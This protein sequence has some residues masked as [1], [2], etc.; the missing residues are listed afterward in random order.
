LPQRLSDATA[1]LLG[2]LGV[3]IRAG[4]RV[5]EIR[6]D[7]ICLAS[8]DFIPSELVVWSAGIRGPD[9]LKDLDGLEASPSGQLVVRPTLQT[10]S[11]DNIFAMGDCA[12]LVPDGE[13]RPIPPRAQ[14]AHQQPK[15]PPLR[16]TPWLGMEDSNRSLS[17]SSA[18]RPAVADG[19]PGE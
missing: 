11:D 6:P 18:R 10:T 3:E 17:I 9:V 15:I 2:Q 16:P 8:G 14:A 5:T 7:G 13:K 1:R 4:A 19:F 12:Y